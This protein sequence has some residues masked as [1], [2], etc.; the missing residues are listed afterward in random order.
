MALKGVIRRQFTSPIGDKV[1][2]RTELVGAEV[3]CAV[4]C[5]DGCVDGR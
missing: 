2:D 3:G 1:I 4:G 5:V